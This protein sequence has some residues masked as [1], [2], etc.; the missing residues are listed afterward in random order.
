ML[1]SIKEILSLYIKYNF[2]LF[3]IVL[4]LFLAGTATG[5][6][7]V[8][9]IPQEQTSEL[10]AYLDNFYQFVSNQNSLEYYHVFL[11]S[12]SYN[13]T[14]LGILWLLGITMVGI[15]IIMILVFLRGIAF[16]FTIGFLIEKTSFMG[17]LLALVSILPHN[18][19]FVPC[20]FIISVAGIS[21]SI[22]LIRN[23]LGKKSISIIPELINYTLLFVIIGVGFVAGS[24]IEAYI[25]P[26]FMR[27]LLQ[28]VQF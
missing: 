21:F 7:T 23:Q 25:S 20:F 24:L 2:I 13:M 19:L 16:G 5:V 6:V 22:L 17:A 15:P 4:L 18:V 28:Y 12:L 27:I 10:E 26:T 9:H 3:L 8:N 14:L 1:N 11:S